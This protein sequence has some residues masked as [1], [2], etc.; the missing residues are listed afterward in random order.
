[1]HIKK[2]CTSIEQDYR[3]AIIHVHHQRM[4]TVYFFIICFEFKTKIWGNI[5]YKDLKFITFI[6]KKH[7]IRNR[8]NYSKYL[9]QDDIIRW[10]E[11]RTWSSWQKKRK[12]ISWEF[13]QKWDFSKTCHWITFAIWPSTKKEPVPLIHPPNRFRGQCPVVSITQKIHRPALFPA[14]KM[15]M[16]PCF[17]YQKSTSRLYL[18]YSQKLPFLVVLFAFPR[19][20]IFLLKFR[21][22]IHAS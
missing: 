18:N 5:F 12:E 3:M 2:R 11:A 16:P 9:T 15:S 6:K 13:I 21:Q 4:D 19:K 20:I 7:P 8:V 1:M 17:Y 14:P 22:H 10:T